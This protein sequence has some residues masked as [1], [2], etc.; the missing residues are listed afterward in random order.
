MPF[1]FDHHDELTHYDAYFFQSTKYQ[2]SMYSVLL[3]SSFNI[4]T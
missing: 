1:Q 2:Y 3:L 4:M